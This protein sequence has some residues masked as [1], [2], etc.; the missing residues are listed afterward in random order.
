MYLL[1]QTWAELVLVLI[2]FIY[3][4]ISL[5]LSSAVSIS[6]CVYSQPAARVLGGVVNKEVYLVHAEMNYEGKFSVSF[7][8][9]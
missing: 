4:V 2:S 8:P 9:N 6:L 5:I 7:G 3:I 1:I